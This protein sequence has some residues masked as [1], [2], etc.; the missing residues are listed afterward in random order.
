MSETTIADRLTALMADQGSAAWFNARL[1]KCTASRL[2]DALGRLK[3][4]GWSES[5]RN[6]MIELA[7][8]RLSKQTADH[9]TSKA[10]K[11]GSE[12]QDAAVANYAL[13][14]NAEIRTVGFIQHPTIAGFGASP[15]ALV[16]DIGMVE[17]KG[18]VS[19]EHV[20]VLLEQAIPEDHIPQVMGQLS[21]SPER[22]WVDWVSYDPRLPAEMQIFTARVYRDDEAI[23]RLENEVEDFLAELD[24]MIAALWRAVGTA[25]PT[26]E[27]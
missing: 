10:M 18:L 15:D 14:T 16:G 12:N 13:L 21:C 25:P 11:W 4:G 7:A 23:R 20:K 2:G 27:S 22:E 8:E 3:R 9:F 26:E 5:R 17:V 24:E 19:K 1:G 6:Y